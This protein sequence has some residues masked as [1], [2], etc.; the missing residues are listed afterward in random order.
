[1]TPFERMI[2]D[3]IRLTVRVLR[4]DGITRMSLANLRQMTPSPYANL[5]GAPRGTNAAYF[6]AEIFE[7]IARTAAKGFIG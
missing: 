6:Y 4:R 5:V 3:N 2:G 7:R 1:M